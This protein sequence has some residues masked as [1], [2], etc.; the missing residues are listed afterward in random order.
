MFVGLFSVFGSFVEKV[1]HFLD[2][3]NFGSWQQKRRAVWR[4]WPQFVPAPHP[5]RDRRLT[6]QICRTGSLMISD[7]SPPSASTCQTISG[8]HRRRPSW[9]RRAVGSIRT[10]LERFR[11]WR[12]REGRLT[13]AM[14]AQGAG[15][16]PLRV[17]GARSQGSPT[18]PRPL[19]GRCGGPDGGEIVL[20]LSLGCGSSE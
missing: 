12:Q 10:R 16:E 4:M 20:A 13:V 19:R 3:K 1:L 15:S 6:R 9:R 17:R 7:R 8:S 11:M 14:L 18:W 2:F 5:A